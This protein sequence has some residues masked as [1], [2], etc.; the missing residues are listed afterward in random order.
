MVA[1]PFGLIRKVNKFV[2]NENQKNLDVHPV[3]TKFDVSK[4]LVK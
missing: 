1:M 4:I 2:V 3:S